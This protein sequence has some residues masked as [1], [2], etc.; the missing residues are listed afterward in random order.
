MK[1]GQL[2][3]YQDKNKNKTAQQPLNLVGCEIIPDPSPDHVYSF[4]ILHNGE[5]LAM[6]EVWM[7]FSPEAG[8]D[9]LVAIQLPLNDLCYLSKAYFIELHRNIIQKAEE[10]AK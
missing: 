2:H 9:S 6:L 7:S 4:R 1:D 8:K 5:E 3:F 10:R